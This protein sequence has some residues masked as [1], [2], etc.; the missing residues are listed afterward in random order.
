MTERT[1]SLSE[2][3]EIICGTADPAALQ[4]LTQRL[5]GNATPVLSGFKV[6]RRW[7][8]TQADVDAAIDALRPKRLPDVPVLTSMTARSRRKLAV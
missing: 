3:A 4:W 2:A 8:M 1:Y 7:R 5:R 6:Q